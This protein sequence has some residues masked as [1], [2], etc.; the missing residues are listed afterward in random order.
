MGLFNNLSGNWLL[1]CITLVNAGMFPCLLLGM[2][3]C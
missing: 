1:A 3:P 2:S